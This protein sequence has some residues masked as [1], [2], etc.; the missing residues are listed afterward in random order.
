MIAPVALNKASDLLPVSEAAFKELR[1]AN[2][3]LRASDAKLEQANSKS[4]AVLEAA[5]A[6]LKELTR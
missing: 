6:K 1:T 4:V 3:E 2:A 5:K